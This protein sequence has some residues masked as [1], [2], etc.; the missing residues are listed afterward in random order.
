MT[1]GKPGRQ[2]RAAEMSA[3][4]DPSR[5]ARLS[6]A[7]IL[8]AAPMG[9]CGRAV[10]LAA[11]SEGSVFL[12]IALGMVFVVSLIVF[13]RAAWRDPRNRGT[14]LGV[15]FGTL[16]EMAV[17]RRV[18]ASYHAMVLIAAIVLAIVLT[19]G[20]RFAGQSSTNPALTAPADAAGARDMQGEP[21]TGLV[22]YAVTLAILLAIDQIGRR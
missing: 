2:A 11:R 14:Y 4:F 19:V 7:W 1:G 10:D 9:G 12:S 6:A 3:G 13:A 17:Y 21:R 15:A 18:P 16:A 20:M 22:A 8:I 5:M